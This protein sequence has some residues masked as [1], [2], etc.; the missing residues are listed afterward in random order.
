MTGDRDVCSRILRSV[1]GLSS[2]RLLGTAEPCSA[3]WHVE[4]RV[5]EKGVRESLFEETANAGEKLLMSKP[6]ETG[7]EDVFLQMT[8][9]GVKK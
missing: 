4:Y 5:S 7:I 9:D 1:K 8:A 3:D 6:M 2:F